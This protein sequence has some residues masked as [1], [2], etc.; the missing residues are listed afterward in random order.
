MS[1]LD[2]QSK[3]AGLSPRDADMARMRA[4]INPVPE[5]SQG[6]GIISGLRETIRPII[7]RVS[8]KI[9][10]STSLSYE[11]APVIFDMNEDG[12]RVPAAIDDMKPVAEPKVSATH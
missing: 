5:S 7:E 1:E 10:D 12:E 4:E 11:A 2:L 6:L 3:L 8:E 9:I